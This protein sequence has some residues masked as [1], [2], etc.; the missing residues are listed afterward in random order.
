MDSTEPR[1]HQSGP[2][3]SDG[4]KDASV[5]FFVRAAMNSGVTP[6]RVTGQGRVMPT[7]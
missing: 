3:P 7:P 2:A 1:T 4:R 5:R 6:R